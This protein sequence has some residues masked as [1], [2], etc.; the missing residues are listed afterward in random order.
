MLVT[1]DHPTPCACKTH[2][3][4]PVPYL[5]Y[6]NVKDLGN[7]AARYT[8]EEAA[9]TGEHVADGYKLIEK[10]LQIKR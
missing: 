6:T 10:L 8:E 9:K 1:P 2:V 5:L 3:S 4:E 7:G